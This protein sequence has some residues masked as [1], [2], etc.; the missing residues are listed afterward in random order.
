MM[1][2]SS[3][4]EQIK[5]SRSFWVAVRLTEETNKEKSINK[6]NSTGIERAITNRGI[7]SC[8]KTIWTKLISTAEVNADAKEDLI[9]AEGELTSGNPK[10]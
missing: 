5:R 9:R 10:E 1:I 3:A 4:L 2:C 7:V 6:T 8:P